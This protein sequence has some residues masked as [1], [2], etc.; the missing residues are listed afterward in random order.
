MSNVSFVFFGT[1]EPAV[2]ILDALF[3]AGLVPALI[4]TNP[5]RPQGRNMALTPPPV[6]LW[7]EKNGI[8]LLQP[9]RFD[10]SVKRPL[11]K[12]SRELFLLVAYGS[13]L[14]KDVLALPKKGVLNVHYSLLPKYRGASPVE[15]QILSD[16]RDTGI[17]ILLL[18]EKMDHGPLVRA[19]K[20]SVKK[21]PPSAPQLRT[22]YNI[23]AGKLLAETISAWVEGR[24]SGVPQDHD[25]A[26]YTKKIIAEDRCLDLAEDGYKNFLKIQAFAAWGTYFF[27]ERQGKKVRVNVKSAQYTDGKLQILRVVPEGKKEMDYSAFLRG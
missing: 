8:A 5:D 26:T 25:R 18:D 22:L 14:P 9:E 24:I 3:A 6:K 11:S 27:A 2:E 19:E 10:D 15:T 7:A 21:W 20:V 4:V 23:V 16:D 1:P 13:I 12:G 17:S